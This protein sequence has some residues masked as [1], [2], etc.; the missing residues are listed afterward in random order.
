MSLFSF[1]S[2]STGF[3]QKLNPRFA[4]KFRPAYYTYQAI[5]LG[6]AHLRLPI[7]LAS[8]WVRDIKYGANLI[9]FAC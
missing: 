8:S 6:R 4:G 7:K 3:P 9:Y 1:T 2:Q 5:F